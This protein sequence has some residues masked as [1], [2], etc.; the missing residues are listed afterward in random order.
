MEA[1]P[2]D[3]CSKLA[4]IVDD[5]DVRTH[6]VCDALVTRT[7]VR[8]GQAGDRGTVEI[9]GLLIG[10]GRPASGAVMPKW[11]A[12]EE[13]QSSA[14]MWYTRIGVASVG[15][16]RGGSDDGFHSDACEMAPGLRVVGS[17]RVYIVGA[18]LYSLNHGNTH[19]HNAACSE[20]L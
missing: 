1:L 6:F 8:V 14:A 5:Q 16:Q 9:T 17:T 3:C 10:A 13:T 20:D 4:G 2:H 7:V 19:V 11:N 18:G 15:W 12:R